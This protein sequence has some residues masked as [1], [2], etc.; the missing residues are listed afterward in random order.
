MGSMVYDDGVI[1]NRCPTHSFVLKT[2]DPAGFNIIDVF[3]WG[4]LGHVLAY[5]VLASQSVANALPK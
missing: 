1:C 2:N 4:A 3:A 5:S